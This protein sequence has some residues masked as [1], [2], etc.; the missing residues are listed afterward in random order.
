M[1]LIT[2]GATILAVQRIDHQFDRSRVAAE[3]ME[4]VLKVAAHLNRHSEN[5]A[6][7]LV[8]GRTEL[9]DLDEARQAV[10]AGFSDL[11]RLVELELG[12][13]Q[14]EEEREDESMERERVARMRSLYSEIDRE[15]ARLLSLSDLGQLSEAATL[16]R[17]S[18]EEGASAE[19]DQIIG[20][21]VADEQAEVAAITAQ[22][23]RLKA[24][25]VILAAT[26]SL[27]ALGVSA[28]AGG[29]LSRALGRPIHELVAG[30]RAIGEG[31][32]GARIGESQPEEFADL[33]RQFN[34]TAARLE[35][36]RR[37]LLDT[38]AGLEAEVARRTAELEDA[39][40]RLQRLD[41]MRM[42]FLA[43]IGHELRTPLTVLRG[44]AE[45]ALRGARPLEEHREALRRVVQ[46]AGQM[47][48]LVED[49]L[50]LA[51]AEV[52]AVRFDMEPLALRDVLDA[53]LLDAQFLAEAGGME[54]VAEIEPE[55]LRIE[56]DAG[57]LAQAF[58]IVL[59]NAVKYGEPGG[60]VEVGLRREGRNAV[61]R[62]ANGGAT[63]PA[64]DLPFVFNRF[65]RARQDGTRRNG[66]G[67]GLPI[68]K[69]VLDT[70]GGRIDLTSAEGRTEAILS[71]PVKD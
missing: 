15:A 62:V 1:L 55:V 54:V 14:S 18:I 59:D 35:A 7:L 34:S 19:L 38:Q 43:D 68:A 6:E 50:F 22:A 39:N 57:R 60:R 16:F 37:E 53:A 45:V 23:D 70:H 48:R 20:A 27:L 8:L 69:W 30:T 46:L 24:Q 33:A 9:A 31:N 13:L 26:V 4:T 61:L 56:G 17:T 51:R 5:V 28:V 58:R 44:E 3:Q 29:R 65:Y 66:A 10:E 63:I 2:A 41:H 67:L 40:A 12:L 71:L 49:L 42:L 47:G 32:L 21:A 52:G 11:D 25:L 64:A 36:Q